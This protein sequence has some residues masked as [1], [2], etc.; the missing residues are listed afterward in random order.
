MSEK[1]YADKVWFG[2]HNDLGRRKIMHFGSELTK[3]M[4]TLTDKSNTNVCVSLVLLLQVAT[5][6]RS[7]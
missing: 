1:A 3:V 2:N 6:S 4:F 7:A 5:K